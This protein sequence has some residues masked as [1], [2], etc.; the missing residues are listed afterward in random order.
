MRAGGELE[1]RRLRVQ[2]EEQMREYRELLEQMRAEGED[3]AREAARLKGQ[4]LEL[5]ERARGLGR[6][7][8][9][10]EEEASRWQERAT[11]AEA[12]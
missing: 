5:R 1:L 4:N 3:R 10:A 12:D 2:S 11:L 6:E 8:E 7:K 9:E